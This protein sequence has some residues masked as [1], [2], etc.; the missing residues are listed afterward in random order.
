VYSGVMLHRPELLE[1]IVDPSR[2]GLSPELAQHVLTLGFT[3]A[4]KAR[5]V[6]LTSKVQSG[7]LTLQE[8]AELEDF[9]AV[10]DLLALL[11]AKAR[12]SLARRTP[13]A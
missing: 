3:A 6:A 11:H 5:Y 1:R 4:D 7:P 13:A 9:V 10:G 8:R 2:G 12:G